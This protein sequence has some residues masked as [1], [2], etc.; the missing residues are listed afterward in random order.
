MGKLT[1]LTINQGL[2]ATLAKSFAQ[3]YPQASFLKGAW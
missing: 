1:P 2:R 3:S